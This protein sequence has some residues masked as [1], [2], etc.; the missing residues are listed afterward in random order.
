MGGGFPHLKNVKNGK[1]LKT[2]QTL[3]TLKALQ[4]KRRGRAVRDGPFVLRQ[5]KQ[6]KKVN[7]IK[8]VP[9]C[10]KLQVSA[11]GRVIRG[12]AHCPVAML[13]KLTVK[14]VKGSEGAREVGC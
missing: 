7:G 2:L 11:L 9:H 3:S 4:V 10:G 6:V 13:R 8:G 1:T 5:V 12:A 14:Q